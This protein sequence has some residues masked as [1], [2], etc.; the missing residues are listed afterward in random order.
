MPSAGDGAP[1][2]V[3]ALRVAASETAICCA[4]KKGLYGRVS[5]VTAA[6]PA[7]ADATAP[8]TVAAPCADRGL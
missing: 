6:V 4:A 8:S 7:T 3:S 1:A 5:T 2:C